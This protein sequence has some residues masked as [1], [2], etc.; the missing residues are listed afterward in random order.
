MSEPKM[1]M[2]KDQEFLSPISW[3]HKRVDD[4]YTDA[5]NPKSMHRVDAIHPDHGSVGLIDWDHDAKT[6]DMIH[7][8]PK[9]RHRGVATELWDQ[10]LKVE[11]NLHHSD[12]LTQQGANWV[13][14]LGPEDANHVKNLED[15]ADDDWDY[16]RTGSIDRYCVKCKQPFSVSESGSA[17][18]FCQNCREKEGLVDHAWDSKDLQAGHYGAKKNCPQCGAITKEPDLCKSCQIQDPLPGFEAKTAHTAI[19]GIG[20]PGSGKSTLLKSFAQEHGYQYVSSDETRGEV[21]GDEGDI[22]K[23]DIVWP[24][25]Y[26]RVHESLGRGTT[27]IDA[28]NANYEKRRDMVRHVRQKASEVHGMFF[29][30]SPEVAKQRNLGRERRVPEEVIDRM[31][32]ALRRNPPSQDDGFDTVTRIGRRTAGKIRYPMD[33]AHEGI[34][35]LQSP[36]P[37]DPDEKK[38]EF[39][40]WTTEIR[41]A[42]DAYLSGPR[43]NDYHTDK[44]G[45]SYRPPG[46]CKNCG[47]QGEWYGPGYRAFCPSCRGTWMSRWEQ[48]PA[49]TKVVTD[50]PEE[51]ELR[52]F[53]AEMGNGPRGEILKQ[54]E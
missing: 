44:D 20:I 29:D 47:Q 45:L 6:V 40:R 19:V 27:V 3:N 31:H 38:A 42:D 23:D 4:P 52:Q 12:E 48:F 2:P 16:A 10:A 15:M 49:G 26:Q 28:T 51:A 21:T 39:K 30:V 17:T 41:A 32:G 24:L 33:E 25:V 13:R 54:D 5:G 37:E 34:R 14:S 36:A 11:P 1:A 7:V 35:P 50:S 46:G 53:D 43:L 8:D 22:S 9:W 18:G